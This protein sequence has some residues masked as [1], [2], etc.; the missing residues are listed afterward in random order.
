MARVSSYKKLGVPLGWWIFLSHSE[1]CLWTSKPASE[2]R[3]H[4]IG[5]IPGPWAPIVAAVIAVQ[6]MYIR[7][8]NE[9]SGGKGVKLL[10]IWATGV[11]QNVNRRGTGK[12]L[13]S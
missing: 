13:C 3:S 11:I 8:L 10:F 2:I 4:L 1:A 5:L 7:S 6:S 9:K 12:S